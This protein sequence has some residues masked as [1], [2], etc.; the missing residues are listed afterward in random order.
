MRSLRIATLSRLAAA[1]CLLLAV[2]ALARNAQSARINDL[3]TLHWR[4][5]SSPSLPPS[6]IKPSDLDVILAV[7]HT[8]PAKLRQKSRSVAGEFGDMRLLLTASRSKRDHS[9]IEDMLPPQTTATMAVGAAV[10]IDLGKTDTI[11]LFGNWT[12]ERRKAITTLPSRKHF[13]SDLQSIGLSWSHDDMFNAS[14][15]RFAAGPSGRRT[16][17]EYMVDLAGGAPKKATGFA[18]TLASIPQTGHPHITYG[19]DV[20]QQ[21]VAKDSWIGRILAPNETIGAVF[22]GYKF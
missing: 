8:G 10:E 4:L 21:H 13:T 1:T 12:K 20:R 14:L 9:L 3:D 5:A 15:A 7:N 17:N 2:P 22:L 19:F 16:P 11:G 18:F 6:S